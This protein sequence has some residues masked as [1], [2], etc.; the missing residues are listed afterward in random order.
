MQTLVHVINTGYPVSAME[1]I[2][3]LAKGQLLVHL[4]AIAI[5][6]ETLQTIVA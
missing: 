2:I 3:S 5:I 6:K 4:V 1:I